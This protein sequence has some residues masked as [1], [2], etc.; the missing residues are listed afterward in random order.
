MKKT[1]HWGLWNL[2]GGLVTAIIFGLLS[3]RMTSDEMGLIALFGMLIFFLIVAIV[4]C[5]EW[6]QR[7]MNKLKIND[8]REDNK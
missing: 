7:K 2:L 8:K 5:Y 6:R 3:R 4:G 1:P